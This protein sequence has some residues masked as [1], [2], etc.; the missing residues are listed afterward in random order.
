LGT[1][2]VY[3]HGCKFK[4]NPLTTTLVEYPLIEIIS[5]TEILKGVKLGSYTAEYKYNLIERKINESYYVGKGDAESFSS[6]LIDQFGRV[7]GDVS[8]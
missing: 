7:Y 4:G 6:Q 5:S 1:Y 8:V 3:K 2:E